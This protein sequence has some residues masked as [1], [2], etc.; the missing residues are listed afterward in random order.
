MKVESKDI[1]FL[2]GVRTAFGDF[3]GSLKDFTAT[4]LGVVAA[5]GAIQAAGIEASDIDHV[6]FGNAN[7]TSGDAI[8]LARH[9]GLRAGVPQEVPAMTL[10]RLCGSGFQSFMTGAEQILLNQA[11]FI[12]AGDTENMSQA[13]FVA[14][15]MRFGMRFGKDQ[16]L[17]DALWESLY[18]PFADMK[19]GETAERLGEQWDISREDCDDY[20]YRSQQAYIAAHKAGKFATE[21]VPV[22]IKKRGKTVTFDQDEHPRFDVSREAMGKLRSVFKKNWLVTAGNASGIC[23]GAGAVVLTTG[24]IAKERGLKPLG[25]L[26]GWGIG[27]VDPRIM[28]FG[29]VPAAKKAFADTGL[30]VADMDLI[31]VNEAFAPQYLAV[32]KALEL[33]REK[34]NVNGGAISVGHPLA[35]SG[36]RITLHLLHELRRTGGRYAMG[37]ACIGGGQGIAVIVEA[38]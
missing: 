3:G 4:D 35:A 25:R 24:A 30:T 21:I 12:L 36:T 38:M 5:E 19:M 20:A 23:D 9:V 14:R 15:D 26:I 18:D 29:P 17:I 32:E 6:L 2:S 31:E 11:D 10:N 27:A 1:V 28:G 7:Q 33:P 22:E 8:Y 16:M 34:T 37:S 13:P